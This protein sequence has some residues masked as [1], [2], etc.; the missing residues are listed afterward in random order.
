MP[1]MRMGLRKYPNMVRALDERHI[2]YNKQLEY[3]SLREQAGAAL[4][5]RPDTPIPI[6]H[7]SHNPDN[8]QAVYDMGRKKGEQMLKEIQRFMRL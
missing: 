6:G 2:M 7:T 3:V 4:V 1:I 5:I 8:M